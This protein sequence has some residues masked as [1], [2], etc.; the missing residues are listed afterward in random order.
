LKLRNGHQD[1][2]A[3]V[4]ISGSRSVALIAIIWTP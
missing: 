4:R 1:N 2:S 3:L